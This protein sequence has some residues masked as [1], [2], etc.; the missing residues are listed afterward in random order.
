[1]FFLGEGAGL[2]TKGDSYLTAWI[3]ARRGEVRCPSTATARGVRVLC[4]PGPLSVSYKTLF[5]D[6]RYLPSW[7]PSYK[8]EKKF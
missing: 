6:A 4:S 1:M 5:P 3:A 8:G 7:L 2:L